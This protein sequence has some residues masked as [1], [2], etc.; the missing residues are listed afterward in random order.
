LVMYVEKKMENVIVVLTSHLCKNYTYSVT[1]IY[2]MFSTLVFEFFE[3]TLS[4][5]LSSCTFGQ[6]SSD[7]VWKLQQKVWFY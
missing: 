6:I 2:T 5:L 4:K 7:F 1:G 3:V